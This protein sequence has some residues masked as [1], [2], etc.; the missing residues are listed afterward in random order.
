MAVD[1]WGSDPSV[2]M[3]RQVFGEL[4]QAQSAFFRR[5]GIPS[6]DQRIRNWRR[7]ARILFEKAWTEADRSGV[8]VT[9]KR[10][11]F[12]Y[13]FCLANRM[14]REGVDIPDGAL[15][16]DPDIEKAVRKVIP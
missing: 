4:E 2:Q 12:I 14:E 9:A 3:M 7:P 8:N 16:I 1:E 10:A 15:P 5:L 13:L 6:M 11:G